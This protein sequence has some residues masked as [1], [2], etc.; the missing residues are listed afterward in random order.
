MDRKPPVRWE[1][2]TLIAGVTLFWSVSAAAVVDPASSWNSVAVQAVLTAGEN[3]PVSSRTLAIVQV[4]IHDALN[5]IDSRYE[6]YAFKGTTPQGS[7]VEAAIAAAGRDALVGAISVGN[8]PFPGFGTAALQAAAVTQVDAQYASLLANIP[9]GIS[10]SDG[11]AIGQ[12]AAAAILALRSTDHAT[13]FV[14]YTPGTRPGD[15]QPTPH[16]VPFD[17]TPAA[18]ILP[19][20]VPGWGKV[21][22]FVLHRSTR[23]EPAG[24]PRL[25]GRRYA[26]DYNE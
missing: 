6:R 1:W 21:T 18:D 19:P 12:A 2:I 17:P 10:K 3:S 11:I 4:A 16:P 23:F 25:S 20:N 5:A 7:S 26:R 14:A 9:T 8:L 15:W 24:P 13:D 22:P